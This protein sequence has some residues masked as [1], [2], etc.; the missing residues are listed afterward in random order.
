MEAMLAVRMDQM[1]KEQGTAVLARLGYTPS[2]AVRKLFDYVVKFE[3]LPF[4]ERTRI[5]DEEM[6]A[7]IAAFDECRLATPLHYSDEEIRD[8]RLGERYGSRS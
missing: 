5:S 1:K 6:R 8:M 2:A 3:A 4:E 7:R